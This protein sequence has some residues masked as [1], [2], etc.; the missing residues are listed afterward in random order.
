MDELGRIDLPH[1]GLSLDTTGS[2]PDIPDD[3]TDNKGTD[4]YIVQFAGPI[5]KSWITELEG[6]GVGFHQYYRYYSFLAKIPSERTDDVRDLPFVNWMGKYQPAYKVA[7]G[8]LDHQGSKLMAVIGYDDADPKDLIS[9]LDSLGASIMTTSEDPPVVVLSADTSLIPAMAALTSVM[10]IHPESMKD[11]LDA[12][13]GRV[14]KYHYAWYPSWSGLPGPTSAVSQTTSLTGRMPGVDG[15]IYNDLAIPYDTDEVEIG[16]V[17]DSG[18]DMSDPNDGHPDFFDSPNGD[19]IVDYY[20]A[21]PWAQMY[22][23]GWGVRCNP[24]GTACA[25]II[26]SDGYA[27]ETSPYEGVQSTT[28]KEWHEGEA[29]VAP[30]AKLTIAGVPGANGAG[31]LGWL[32]YSGTSCSGK[33]CWDRMYL[34]DGAR[35]ISNSWGGVSGY[36]SHIDT[37]IDKWNDLMVLMAAGNSGPSSD[38]IGDGLAKNKNGLTIGAS[39]NYRPEWFG[40]DN[41][42]LMADFSS[43]GGTL[44]S[45]GRIKPEVVAIGTAGI[46]TMGP[47][48]Y[49]CNKDHPAYGG[50]VPQPSYIMDV[51]EYDNVAKGPGFDGIN[52]Y[53]Y[54]SG[55]SQ[56]TPMAAGVFMLIR[57]HLR[58]N[59]GIQN[60]S[61][62]LAKALMING[63]VRMSEELYDYPGWD[64]GWGRV[65]VKESIFP[66]PPRTN[67]FVEGQFN[68]S[69]T[70]DPSTGACVG[71]GN[72]LSGTINTNVESGNTPLKVTLVWIDSQGEALVRNLDLRVVSPSGVEYRG[73][74]YNS[75]GEYRGWSA[76]DPATGGVDNP[77]W[78]YWDSTTD[79][80]DDLNVVEQVEVKTPEK[81]VWTV[82]IIGTAIPI[83]S[84]NFSLVFSADVGPQENYNVDLHSDYPPIIS[85]TIN[86]TASYPFTVTNFGSMADVVTVIS[87]STLTVDFNPP[88]PYSLESL[89]SKDAIAIIRA[90]DP[91]LTRG[92]YPVKLRAISNGDST[93]QDFIDITVEVLST[94]IPAPYQLTTEAT[95]DVDP[96]ILVF[97]NGIGK[98]IFVAY[99]KTTTI[100]GQFGGDNVWMAHTT[101]DENGAPQEPWSHQSISNLNDLPKDLRLNYFRT[102]AYEGR[103]IVTWT[104]YDPAWGDQQMDFGSWGRIAHSDPPYDTWNVVTIDRNSGE[105]ATNAKR[106][107]F[108][109]IRETTQEIIFVFEYLGSS[110]SEDPPSI[111]QTWYSVSTDQHVLLLPDRLRGPERRC[112]DI[113]VFQIAD[114]KRQGPQ[115]CAV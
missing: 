60:P 89:E 96:S 28:D 95:N 50:G 41:P 27:W 9:E 115:A 25:G 18:F 51:D 32:S 77:K 108:N 7:D 103:V 2:L 13:A 46:T 71:V 31:I 100:N 22:P 23:D 34:D 72:T 84:A 106:V 112:L 63:A 76:P 19:R 91:G 3:L 20:A 85:V 38:T 12:V 94:S 35:T 69:G 10:E 98:H 73:N 113:R 104:G 55:T 37:R 70:C 67:Q 53:V 43:R 62:A 57:E 52:D 101:L 44:T 64:Q 74:A 68:N 4:E 17:V 110:S 86:G 58:E 79:N 49:L 45:F 61:S 14:H 97:N 59:E 83:G 114:G 56:A 65:N 75:S 40:A 33:P 109:L 29:G 80:W 102:G 16:G 48:G 54:F 1:A 81:G 92:I 30:E 107:N 21:S 39:Q 93:K 99:I 8:L 42:N 111:V 47:G 11:T 90:D 88:S 66:T 105:Q 24:H 82:E 5:T 78:A 87:E 26:A 6:M 36:Q 15:T